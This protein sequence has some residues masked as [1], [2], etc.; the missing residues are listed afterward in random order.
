MTR[1]EKE[2]IIDFLLMI[3]NK[4]LEEEYETTNDK[5]WL[6]DY[7]K[8]EQYLLELKDTMPIVVDEIIKD[9]IK[10]YL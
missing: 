8:A 6:R 9:D 10:K 7:I 5:E 4:E 3:I 1:Y 2:Q